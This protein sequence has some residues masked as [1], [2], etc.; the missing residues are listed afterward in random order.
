MLIFSSHQKGTYRCQVYQLN[1]LGEII[2]EIF[3]K[4]VI[5]KIKS[6]PVIIKKQPQALSEIKEGDNLVL[7][8]E[9]VGYPSP[10]FQWYRNNERL[11]NQTFNILQV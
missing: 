11:D 9:A 4:H 6:T 5:V 10:Q 8:C 1:H 2:E 7:C 3:S